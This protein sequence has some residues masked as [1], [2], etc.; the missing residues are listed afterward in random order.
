MLQE[1]LIF[2]L[3]N[4]QISI[5]D[6]HTSIK[7]FIQNRQDGNYDLIIKKHKDSRTIRQ[8]NYYWGI[9]IPFI[10]AFMAS[11]GHIYTNEIAHWQIK[12]LCH[13]YE[14]RQVY[15][16]KTKLLTEEKI[17]YTYKNGGDLSNQ[18]FSE[19]IELLRSYF[20]DISNGEWILPEAEN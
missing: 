12:E 15:N 13:H 7:E 9:I 2:S 8:N 4:K 3:K 20:L 10:K 5:L 6:Q 19:M 11:L 1:Q 16:L 17:Y 18:Q 14:L